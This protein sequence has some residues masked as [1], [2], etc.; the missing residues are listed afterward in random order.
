VL[1]EVELFIA[2]EFE[3]FMAVRINCGRLVLHHVFPEVDSGEFYPE[4]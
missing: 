3:V 1:L 4:D 2:I